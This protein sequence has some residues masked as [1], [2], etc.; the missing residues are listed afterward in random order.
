MGL[1][2]SA[3]SASI[4]Q[5]VVDVLW[6]RRGREN[7]EGFKFCSECGSS[8]QVVCPSCEAMVDPGQ[9]LCGHCGTSLAGDL[10]SPAFAP[11]LRE[12]PP[13]VPVSFV[14]GR[15]RVVKSLGEGG[16]RAV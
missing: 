3:E 4:G 2:W 9:K 1:R 14:G 8:L 12:T 15:Y 11:R 13:E 6:P 7:P 10:S 16:K 5:E